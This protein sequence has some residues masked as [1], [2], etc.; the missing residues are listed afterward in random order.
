MSIIANIDVL[1]INYIL[2]DILDFVQLSMKILIGI[3]L[4]LPA[5]YWFKLAWMK[6]K[7]MT[8]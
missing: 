2:S 1:K 4:I 7:Q 8:G 3:I 5:L 6:L